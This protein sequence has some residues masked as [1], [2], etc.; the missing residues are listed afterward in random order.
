MEVKAGYKQTEVGVIPEDWEV[1][2]IKEIAPLQRGFDLPS[3]E[4]IRG[5]YPVV[6]SNGVN[7]YHKKY[8]VKGPGVITGR[9]GTIG[10]VHYVEDDYWPH[11]TTLWVKDFI[12]S[13]PKYIYY[14]YYYIGFSRFSSGSG[15]PTL[16]RN[17]AHDFKSPLPPTKDE[18]TAIATALSDV[19]EW[20]AAQE[21]LIQKKRRIKE[22]AMQ[23]LLTGK[24]RLEGFGRGAGVKQTEVG[25][26]PEDW[27]VQE[28]FDITVLMTN[29]FVGLSKNHYTDSDDGVLYIQGY[30]VEENSFN[31]NGIKKV[32][33][34][35]HNKHL[36]SCLKE[37]DLLTVQT[38]DVGLTTIIP[39]YL[40]G[41]NCHALIITRF[42]QK[43]IE[44][45]FCSFYLNSSTGRSRLKEIE[46]GTTMKHINVGDLKWF[47]I[48]LPPTK[49]EQTAIAR[50]L[51][52]MDEEIAELE[53]KLE[54]SRELKQGMM[55]QLLTGKIRL[56]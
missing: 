33:R 25:V 10:K 49:D 50:V 47:K 37:N 4:C 5:K 52:D 18:Q 11:N 8:Q 31:F 3:H 55:Q 24:K 1:K 36:K 12:G 43:T 7:F 6:Y 45:L 20:I 2:P 41:S 56:V 22:G 15:V 40:E 14:L 9:S 54:K 46:T 19:D 32:E 28:L 23:Q 26:I 38:G 30:N 34:S 29:G 42:K 48:P 16:N 35:F 27:E 44:P 39:K 53:G 21:L 17:D 51:S 13:V